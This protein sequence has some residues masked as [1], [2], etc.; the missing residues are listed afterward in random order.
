MAPT[1]VAVDPPL[2]TST[3]PQ[4]VPED[5]SVATLVHGVAWALGNIKQ[6]LQCSEGKKTAC[7]VHP[8]DCRLAPEQSR[9]EG[10]HHSQQTESVPVVAS[11][12]K[13]CIAKLRSLSG[14]RIFRRPPPEVDGGELS[15]FLARSLS[16]GWARCCGWRWEPGQRTS[17][18]LDEGRLC[19]QPEGAWGRCCPWVMTPR[20]NCRVVVAA[21]P[22]HYLAD[23]RRLRRPTRPT[24]QADRT[25]AVA[26]AVLTHRAASR[27]ARLVASPKPAAQPDAAGRLS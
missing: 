18:R 8:D 23:V 24:Q 26:S 15:R 12:E 2:M 9:P 27:E 10:D 20:A 17:R 13:S 6:K 11:T 4:R 22:A 25:D 1:C 16:R 14:G 21:A 7:V 19:C 5:A 3:L